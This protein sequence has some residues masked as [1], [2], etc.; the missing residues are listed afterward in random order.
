ML[1][2]GL[3]PDGP[4]GPG[5]TPHGP[6]SLD[7]GWEGEV[8]V[9]RSQPVPGVTVLPKEAHPAWLAEGSHGSCQP[10]RGESLTL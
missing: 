1:C 5:H 3:Q 7:M 10:W 2:H 6:A 9:P 8:G 4:P